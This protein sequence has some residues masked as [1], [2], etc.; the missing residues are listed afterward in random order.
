MTSLTLFRPRY[1]G[2]L[3]ERIVDVR[4]EEDGLHIIVQ[5]PLPSYPD[6]TPKPKFS[7]LVHLRN[8][9]Y[10]AL[11]IDTSALKDL[12]IDLILEKD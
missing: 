4:N 12:D 10:P 9:E 1:S 5:S 11:V 2:G 7:E 8:G 3:F 6:L